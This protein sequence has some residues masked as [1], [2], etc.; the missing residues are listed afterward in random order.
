[1]TKPRTFL[2]GLTPERFLRDY[3]QKR[4][5]LVRGAVP[6]YTPPLD[7]NELAGLAC[8]AGIEAR[9]ITRRGQRYTLEN[10]PFQEERFAQLGK[11]NWTL[12]VQD[13]DQHVPAVGA[14]LSNLDF[15][16]SWRIDDV[17]ASFAADGGTVGP[18]YDE[19]DVFLLQVEGNRRWQITERFERDDL[20]ETSR[21]KLLRHFEPQEEWVLEAGDMLYL[22]PHVAHFGVAQGPCVTYSLGCRA[23]SVQDLVHHFARRMAEPL[24]EGVR[25][26]DP[27][28]RLGADRYA[29]DPASV[30]RAS[31]ALSGALEL[32]AENVARTL[33]TLTSLPKALFTQEPQTARTPSQV[34]RV[35]RSSKGLSRALGSRWSYHVAAGRKFLFVSGQEYMFT[36]NATFLAYL[37]AHPRLDARW[38]TSALRR[39]N[40]AAL[41]KELVQQRHLN[42]V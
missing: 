1:M 17:M 21:L 38:V 13:L 16:P 9:L 32:T 15:L 26:R 20:V 29:I 10:G 19:Y 31:A 23:P 3:F 40:T 41:L 14:L 5:L 22:P 2:G 6:D 36:G 12:L 25:Y 37:C 39:S 24:D 42:G 8:E 28:L 30:K 4:P 35:L 18:H 33:G 11:R 34:E 27:T 7:A